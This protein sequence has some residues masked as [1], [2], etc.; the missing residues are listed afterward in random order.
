[1]SVKL[2]SSFHMLFIGYR[3][4]PCLVFLVSRP[5]GAASL[6][7]QCCIDVRVNFVHRHELSTERGR[8]HPGQGR[9]VPWIQSSNLWRA[10]VA[11]E[12][13]TPPRARPKCDHY[14]RDIEIVDVSRRVLCL[15]RPGLGR[16]VLLFGASRASRYVFG[17]GRAE[18]RRK[19]QARID[20]S[21]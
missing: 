18:R 21:Q 3:V 11:V 16:R 13:R 17:P 6:R 19:I 9:S 2:R 1:M 5:T 14:C 20:G 10:Y 8:H 15:C 4:L 12:A 7:P